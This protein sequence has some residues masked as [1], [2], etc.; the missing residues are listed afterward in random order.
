MTLEAPVKA[1]QHG[2]YPRSERVVGLT[3]DLERGRATP[4]QVETAFSRDVDDFIRVQQEAQLDYFS[5]GLLR[6][7]DIFRPLVE[8]ADGMV[9]GGLQR[10]FDNNAFFRAPLVK[11]DPR[12]SDDVPDVLRDGKVPQPRV[13]TL[14][15]PFMFSRAA[16]ATIDRNRLMREL[17]AEVLAPV[18]RSLAGQGAGLIQL[19]EP[20]LVYYGA[21]GADWDALGEAIAAIRSGI[22]V[23]VV[24]HTYYGDA[25]R[26]ADQLRALPVDAVGVDAVMTDLERLKGPWRT[27]LLLGCLDGR[28]SLVEETSE[29][30]EM[31]RQL[32]GRLKPASLYLSSNSD[33]ELLPQQVA[34][35]KVRRLGEIMR[36]VKEGTR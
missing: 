10:W 31:V 14:P 4:E 32:I 9:P 26:V 36:L 34:A 15:S 7:Q 19:Q 27:G 12:L 30:V 17:A 33:L 20:W 23:P 3:R 1:Y 21:A 13:I 2:I 29:V 35:G 5:D 6:W 8:G 11:A 22:A 28:S 24:L 25:A 16:H 18:A